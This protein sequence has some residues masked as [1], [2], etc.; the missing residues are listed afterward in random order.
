MKAN[1]EFHGYER[2]LLMDVV[3]LEL[4]DEICEIVPKEIIDSVK[5]VIEEEIEKL[6]VQPNPSMVIDILE[7][8]K[9]PKIL[10]I[11]KVAQK[12]HRELAARF[13]FEPSDFPRC[14]SKVA[15]TRKVVQKI[16]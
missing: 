12:L 2:G 8:P 10:F 5:K 1:G 14:L 6:E 15:M 13:G 16:D 9:D 4:L 3:Q 7:Q 11:K